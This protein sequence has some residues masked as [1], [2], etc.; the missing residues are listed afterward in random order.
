MTRGD[1]S[2]NFKVFMFSKLLKSL[3]DRERAWRESFGDDISTPAKRREAWRHFNWVDHAFLRK[4]WTNF[5]EVA[6]G[7]FRSNQPSPKRLHDYH[8]RGIKSILNLRGTSLYSYYLFES[9]ACDA[10]GLDLVNVNLSAT[11]LPTLKT[12]LAL[13]Q[14]F[15]TLPKPFVMHCKSGADRAGFASALYLLLIEDAPTEAAQKQLSFRYL[16]IKS[17]KKGVLDFCLEKYRQTNKAS[18][19]EFRAWLMDMYDP[20]ALMDEFSASRGKAGR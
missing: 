7:V 16:H 17:S 19:I 11:V 12:I 10:L 13:E 1:P 15:K 8:A 20:K 18:P 5:D 6:Q 14:H 2:S 4:A 9:E 3:E